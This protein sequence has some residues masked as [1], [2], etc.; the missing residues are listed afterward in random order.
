MKLIANIK[1]LPTPEQES[2]LRKT[3]ELCNQVCNYLSARAFDA[4]TFRQFDLHKIGYHDA[5]GMYDVAAQVAVRCISKVA[6]SYKTG[7]EG[8]RNFKRF[9]AQP[10]DD[11]IFRFLGD[12]KVSIW[13]VAGRQKIDYVCGERQ[14]VLLEFRK[15]EVDLMF[16][17]G[18]WYLACVCDIPDPEEAGIEDVLG[19]DFGIVNL[20]V[21]SNGTCY[22]GAAVEAARSKF[23]R[24]R[25]GLQK[26][27]TK[28]AKRRLRKLSGRQKRFQTHT[29]HCI[30]KAIVAEAQRSRSAISLEDLKGIRNRVKARR[31]QRAKLH[32]W[33]FGQL[34][35]FTTYKSRLCGVLV[36]AIDPRNTSRECSVCGCIDKRNRPNQATFLCTNCGHSAPA[37]Y[38]A[39]LNIKARAAKSNPALKFSDRAAA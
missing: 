18:K 2:L 39:A 34:R 25:A 11:R 9:A 33:A 4:Q 27:G 7:A 19:V 17:R 38:N 6:D 1:L 28:A 36:V 30:S 21:D 14:R 31:P 12:N 10:F 26:R 35:D 23:A 16:V 3:L 5:R 20:A 24:R 13:T 32:N 37:D 15:G 22:S 29:N 8:Q